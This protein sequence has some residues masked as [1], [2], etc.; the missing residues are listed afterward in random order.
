MRLALKPY[1][2][3]V[4]KIINQSEEIRFQEHINYGCIAQLMTEEEEEEE[5][6]D[7]MHV[8]IRIKQVLNELIKVDKLV[9][10]LT[11]NEKDV[12]R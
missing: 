11:K 2:C 12:P 5:E 4:N 8:E 3:I 10:L 1:M 9:K 7:I 6:E